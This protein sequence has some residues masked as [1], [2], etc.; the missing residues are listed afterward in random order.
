[1][2][3]IRPT[4][5]WANRILR[6]LTSI[7]HRLEKHQDNLSIL[8]NV[9]VKG[10]RGNHEG[11]PSASASTSAN[12]QNR[13][14]SSSAAPFFAAAA[15]STKDANIASAREYGSESNSEPDDPVWVPGKPVKR[16]IRHS[17]SS[18][19]QGSRG[20]RRRSRMTIRSPEVQ[21]TLPGA[22][23][24]VTPLI[25]GKKKTAAGLVEGTVLPRRLF[26]DGAGAGAGA[27]TAAVAANGRRKT[28]ASYGGMSSTS[29]TSNSFY[30]VYNTPWKEALDRCGNPGLADIVRV[31]DRLLIK[32]LLSTRVN[33]QEPQ[34]H[35]SGGGARSLFS[36][37]VRRLPEFIAEE[38]ILQSAEKGRSDEDMCDA[39]FT[40]LEACYAPSG[41]GW[42]P[43]REAVRAQGISLVSAMLQK[44]C[45]T[46]LMI[47][48]LLDICVERQEYDAVESL[49]SGLLAS[50]TI[51]MGETYDRPT[52][53]DSGG[54]PGDDPV[55]FLYG[56]WMRAP[57]RRAF[58]FDEIAKLLLCGGL[59][60]EWMVTTR[61]KKIVDAAIQSLS[62][63]ENDSAAAA[64]LLEAVL[65][66]ASGVFPGR[67]RIE[68][69]VARG[70][71]L[72]RMH[73]GQSGPDM[74]SWAAVS[75]CRRQQQ[76]Q[77]PS[78]IPIQ[79]ALSNLA[80]SLVT[81]LC[82]MHLARSFT[83]QQHQ[84]HQGGVGMRVRTIIGS[85]AFH[86]QQ[87]IE[88]YYLSDSMA[89]LLSTPSYALRRSSILLG[90]SLAQCNSSH[91]QQQL[92]TPTPGNN[93]R[94]F[95]QTVSSRSDII[96][97]LADLARQVFSC[98]QRVR[99]TVVDQPGTPV[100]VR[101]RVV[102]LTEMS[103]QRCLTLFLGRV[104]A[105][106]AMQMAE[107]TVDP[108]DHVWAVEVQERV[109]ARQ[110]CLQELSGDTGATGS[111]DD[112]RDNGSADEG[113]G[114]YR[115][116]E[117]IE[118]WVA[119][120]PVT[121]V[122]TKKRLVIERSVGGHASNSSRASN[123]QSPSRASST[124][125]HTMSSV[126]S[127]ASSCLP[128][129]RSYPEP[130]QSAKKRRRP[131]SW[132]GV[133]QRPR[134]SST[135]SSSTRASVVETTVSADH[136]KFDDH[137]DW[138][139]N[140]R[141][142]FRRRN[143][144]MVSLRE[145]MPM[146]MVIQGLNFDHHLSPLPTSP[147]LSTPP[148]PPP[149][150][151]PQPSVGYNQ[152]SPGYQSSH[153]TSSPASINMGVHPHPPPEPESES[154]PDEAGDT[155]TD[156]DEDDLCQLSRSDPSGKASRLLFCGSTPPAKRIIPRRPSISKPVTTVS[157]AEDED[158]DDELSF[159]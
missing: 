59:P 121:K 80:S 84:Q 145:P 42:T 147:T 40:E 86:V 66:S 4:A 100:D 95:Y 78:P 91:Y 129:K 130:A 90:E 150:Q 46:G 138:Q 58:V 89:E 105:E 104:A 109:A 15:A 151:F 118:E 37:A 97:E 44:P 53:F 142:E 20:G 16:R 17:Y 99:R 68:D 137:Y 36:T 65:L 134:A 85:T 12:H 57:G 3:D 152:S 126:T 60:A 1:M 19:G 159:L 141:S 18:R 73:P 69:I 139:N 49:L 54:F 52:A 62:S 88:M 23:E 67:R 124:P 136:E 30:A 128:L 140:S 149:H 123:S 157:A 155:D 55:Q 111:D 13:P 35:G 71:G 112:R 75:L 51:T 43:L 119:A 41:N 102:Q 70:G 79:D 76:Q 87:E 93:V 158:S 125:E 33:Q 83:A 132:G 34:Q 28:R 120:T 27:A 143:E 63:E 11:W 122:R 92:S 131:A 108:D 10:P 31:L 148:P 14:R 50:S 135:S 115:W 127:S 64:H 7:H 48:R 77:S 110:A 9:N 25:T 74:A 8:A 114:L 117:S 56:Y 45:F 156:T 5:K 106:T 2:G 72:D 38:Q 94:T 24:I 144:L 29:T 116:E 103:N 82:G 47:C 39:Y 107:S 32:F 6:P 61:W 98:T 26:D 101:D 96:K 133:M 153:E 21:R 81:A 146:P 22:I 113:R 154:E